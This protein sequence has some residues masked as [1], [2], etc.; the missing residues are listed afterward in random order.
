M[1]KI[2]FV[3]ITTTFLASWLA[4]TPT[5]PTITAQGDEYA[6]AVTHYPEVGDC[7]AAPDDEL[8]VAYTVY[9]NRENDPIAVTPEDVALVAG[10]VEASTGVEI[11][12][13]NAWADVEAGSDAVQIV[14]NIPIEGALYTVVLPIGW[15]P[16]GSYPVVLSGNGAG[17]S[18][19]N[20]LYGKV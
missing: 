15:A 2:C 6:C 9:N 18:N 11:V 4:M 20:R 19:N 10:M 17:T 8:E 5:P 3:L 16:D 13:L 12:I 7:E 14:N 1:R